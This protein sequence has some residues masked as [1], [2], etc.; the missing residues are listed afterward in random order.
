MPDKMGRHAAFSKHKQK[1]QGKVA[2]TTTKKLRK[3]L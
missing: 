2:K 3:S 1:G